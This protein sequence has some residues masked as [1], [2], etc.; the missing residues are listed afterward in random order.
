M[1]DT[2]SLFTGTDILV[3]FLGVLGFAAVAVVFSQATALNAKR[4]LT[5]RQNA[6]RAQSQTSD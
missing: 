6:K 3:A 4:E 1:P 5:L 2:W